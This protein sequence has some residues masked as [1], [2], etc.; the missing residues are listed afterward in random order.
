MLEKNRSVPKEFVSMKC[1]CFV[2]W[3]ED[4]GSFQN[5]ACHSKQEYSIGLGQNSPFQCTL[6]LYEQQSKYFH[7]E[8]GNLGILKTQNVK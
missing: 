1:S 7:W 6:N 3:T 2:H 5:A 8:E 4:D